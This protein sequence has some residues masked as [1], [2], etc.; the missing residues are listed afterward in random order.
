[1]KKPN[2]TTQKALK[3][4][5]DIAKQLEKDRLGLKPVT[6]K[7]KTLLIRALARG[8]RATW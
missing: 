4:A 5:D 2:K 1:M 3:E 7:A 6:G 8:Q